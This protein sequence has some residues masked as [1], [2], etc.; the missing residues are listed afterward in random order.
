MDE[1]D[2][3]LN[4]HNWDEGKDSLLNLFGTSMQHP[5]EKFMR[6]FGGTSVA[7]NEQGS[8]RCSPVIKQGSPSRS[9]RDENQRRKPN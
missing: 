7:A 4:K 6:Y 9:P 2:Y 5:E 3:I 1:E 8:P